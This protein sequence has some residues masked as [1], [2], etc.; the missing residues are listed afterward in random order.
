MKN[1]S[2]SKNLDLE[3][4]YQIFSKLVIF[5]F[6]RTPFLYSQI[7][8]FSTSLVDVVNF[9]PIVKYVFIV[10]VLS[11][12]LVVFEN[13][14]AKNKFFAVMTLTFSFPLITFK[15]NQIK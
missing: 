7:N 9:S 1:I 15:A 6:C 8:F 5:Y 12:F 11:V 3:M 4:N 2:V 10:V 14:Q 13:A